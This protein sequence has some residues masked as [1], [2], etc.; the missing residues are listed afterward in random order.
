MCAFV[1]ILL[2]YYFIQKNS[3]ENVEVLTT[4]EIGV[5]LM[6]GEMM[7]SGTNRNSGSSGAHA[8]I[9]TKLNKSGGAGDSPS[10]GLRASGGS[11]SGTSGASA[12]SASPSLIASAG[13]S[14]IASAGGA[15][16]GSASLKTSGGAS[17]G[18]VWEELD[19]MCHFGVCFKLFGKDTKKK[20]MYLFPSLG[21]PKGMLFVVCCLLLLV[22]FVIVGDFSFSLSPSLLLSSARRIVIVVRLPWVV[23]SQL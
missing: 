23:G 16:G 22:R 14:V 4:E 9:A 11:A 7:E 21:A 20:P 2:L 3:H 12:S 10:A 6:K 19:V 8:A 18:S 15:S 1:R 17:G 13:A 5:L